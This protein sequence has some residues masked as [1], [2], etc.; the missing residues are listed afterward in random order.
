MFEGY[1]DV[2]DWWLRVAWRARAMM[3]RRVLDTL[4]ARR[5]VFV[6]TCWSCVS[7]LLWE[8]RRRKEKNIPSSYFHSHSHKPLPPP[9]KSHST[10][11]SPLKSPPKFSNLA[12]R[13]ENSKSAGNIRWTFVKFDKCVAF[14]WRCR[15]WRGWGLSR[16]GGGGG[17][18]GG[19]LVGWACWWWVGERWMDGWNEWMNE[20]GWKRV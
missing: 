13:N 1:L 7:T 3:E 19:G 10:P 2:G 6:G 12:Y 5:M 16:G 11:Q 20:W 9:Q 17:V 15:G 4:E 8:W 14:G 18:G